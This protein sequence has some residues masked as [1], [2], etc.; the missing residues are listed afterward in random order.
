M[1]SHAVARGSGGILPR[2]IFDKNGAIWCNLGRPKVCYY[3]PKI[4]NFK[5]KNEQENLI[6][7]LP[8]KINLDEHV[9]TKVNTFR[10]YKGVL[11]GGG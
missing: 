9:S 10:I 1:C 3:Q 4:N 2:K 6:A 7:I 11:G 8:S 5:G